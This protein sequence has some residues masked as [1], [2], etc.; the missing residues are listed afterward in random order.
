MAD[1]GWRRNKY[2]GW[3]N[4]NEIKNKQ[5]TNEYMNNKI[6]QSKNIITFTDEE[7]KFAEK[8]KNKEVDLYHGTYLYFNKFD[9]DYIGS[10]SLGGLSYGKGHYFLANE[11]DVYSKISYH[12]KTTMK[13]PFVCEANNWSPYLEKMG[14]KWGFEDNRSDFLKSKGYDSTIIIAN[15]KVEEIVIY[16]NN[17][18]KIKI[19][20]SKEREDW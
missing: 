14:Y 7:K 18:N 12:V 3:F 6:R 8:Y 20:G 17:D 16:T 19:I 4:I 13:N 9:D 15:G 2:G 1:T 10:S 5:T 11:K